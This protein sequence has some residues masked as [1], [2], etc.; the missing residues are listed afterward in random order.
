MKVEPKPALSVPAKTV[1]ATGIKHPFL[2]IALLLVV[3]LAFL[4]RQS[5]HSDYVAYSNDGPYGL[6][7]AEC[8]S[9]PSTISGM[10]FDLGWLGNEGISAS[11]D[12]TTALL[13][14]FPLH[15]YMNLFYPVSL[16]IVGICACF[17]LRQF[18]LAPLACILGGLAAALNSDFFSTA[19]WGVAPQIISFGANYLA[20]GLLAGASGRRSWIRVILAGLAVGLGV[21]EGF[22]NGAIFSLFVAAFALFQALFLQEG[23]AGQKL[24]RG[25]LRIALVALFAG[26]IAV[27]TLS[28]LVGTQIKG[29]AA[30]QQDETTK[31]ARWA[32]ATEW[33]LPPA[34]TLQ[35]LVPGLFGYRNVWHMYENDQPKDDQYWGS[36]GAGPGMWRLIGTGF[37]GSVLVVTLALWAVFQSFR[38]RGSPFSQFQ[39]RLIWFWSAVLIVALLL[40]FGKFGPLYRLFYALPFASTIRNPVKFMHVF[41]WALVVLFGFGVHGLVVCYL[42]SPVARVQGWFAQFKKWLAGAA[43]FEKKWMTACFAAIGISLFGWFIYASKGSGLEVYLQTVGISAAAAP[44]IAKF[45][46]QA[47]GWYILFLVLT[48]GLLA[49]IFSGQFAGPRAKWAGVLLGILLV[50]DLGRADRPWI[51][52]YDMNYKFASDPIIDFLA[53]KP[54]EHRVSL[55]LPPGEANT[56]QQAL[57]HNAYR[58]HWNQH[59]F[60]YHNIQCLDVAQEP[61]VA[62]DKE[63]F[64][65]ALSHTPFLYIL[66]NTRYFLGLGGDFAKQNDPTG[67]HLRVLKTFNFAPKTST[68]TAEP[69]DWKTVEDPNGELAVI[70]YADALPRAKLF[71]NWQVNTNDDETL[72]RLASPAFDPHQTVFVANQ[73]SASVA[74]TANPPDDAVKITSYK[75]KQIE[76]ETDAKTSSVLLLAERFNPKW[77]VEVDGKP[78]TLLR[79]NF[80]ERG[81]YLDPGKHKVIFRFVPSMATFYTSLA[82]VFLGI[83]LSGWLAFDKSNGEQPDAPA[84]SIDASKSKSNQG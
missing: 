55:I 33:S 31:A 38:C 28:L 8:T 83:V 14:I 79:C 82:G 54:F 58:S 27:H 61:R 77:R 46:L 6:Q 76:L 34:E 75:S 25:I 51:V 59:L 16:F 7:A 72:G 29:V 73:I 36:I 57:L 11:P 50:V 21:M 44:G 47:V 69:V 68:P 35:V 2:W 65:K 24:G 63:K 56:M 71:S 66:S 12:V 43:P 49:L 40:A 26:F 53:V 4:F 42:E 74:A 45:S 78:A 64:V 22:D 81:V 30:A 32:E 9:M 18:K 13:S 52:Y 60:P 70:E 20:L 3:I 15:T 62:V 23:S 80:I 41:S 84:S 67:K 39:R 17:C 37:Y 48:V 1:G 10:W 19:V 5:F